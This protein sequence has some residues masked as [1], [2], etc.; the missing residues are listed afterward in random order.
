MDNE[1]DEEEIQELEEDIHCVEG[2]D[3]EIF[4]TEAEY[5]GSLFDEQ[6]SQL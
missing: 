5:E 3:E 6:L 4:L 1:E 2:G